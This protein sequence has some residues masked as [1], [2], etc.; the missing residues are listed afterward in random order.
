MSEN[1]LVYNERYCDYR[2]LYEGLES[3]WDE[4]PSGD[5]LDTVK[6]LAKNY[7]KNID[8]IAAFMLED[9]QEM[10]DES[11]TIDD[12][13]ERIGIPQIDP[14]LGTVT[15]CEQTFD[16]THIFCFEFWDDEFEDLNY[17]AIDG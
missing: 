3:C 6:V 1:E 5:Y 11:I 15:Y 16:Y 9:I 14:E 4:K 17:F 13:K 7:H 8:K 2:L 10:Y 12:V